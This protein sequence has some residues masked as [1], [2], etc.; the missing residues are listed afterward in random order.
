MVSVL[1]LSFPSALP[2]SLQTVTAAYFLL[3]LS[4]F[5]PP[6]DLPAHVHSGLLE[7]S[8]EQPREGQ[9]VSIPVFLV[10]LVSE[11]CKPG[12]FNDRVGNHVCYMR[13]C[14]SCVTRYHLAE[15]KIPSIHGFTTGLKL[16][17]FIFDAFTYSPSTALFEVRISI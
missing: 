4:R 1:H 6:L 17:Q 11:I 5:P 9:C 8:G 15:K 3:S 10:R 16:E 7:P 2:P 12:S 13:V 14:V